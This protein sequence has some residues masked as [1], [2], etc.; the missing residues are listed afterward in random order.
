MCVCVCLHLTSQSNNTASADPQRPSD[1]VQSHHATAS[2][3]HLCVDSYVPLTLPPP[4]PVLPKNTLLI[5]FTRP[6]LN[7]YRH[8]ANEAS[9]MNLNEIHKWNLN[10]LESIGTS[11]MAESETRPADAE[12]WRARDES[13]RWKRRERE[14]FS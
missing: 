11:S 13:R 7:V 2:S 12:R 9:H 3:F 8:P 4:S 5:C 14:S 6:S 1:T 10:W